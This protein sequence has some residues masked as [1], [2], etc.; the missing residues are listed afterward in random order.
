MLAILTTP[1]H[2]HAVLNHLPLVGLLAAIPVLLV[3]AI[4]GNRATVIAGL[5][6]MILFG[7][8]MGLVMGSGEEAYERFE[9]GEIQ[10]VLDE[11]GNEWMHIHEER[12]HTWSKLVYA[13]TGLAVV[14]LGFVIWKKPWSRYVAIAGIVLS[15]GC[16][17]AMAYVAEAG[18]KIRHPEFRETVEKV[19]TDGADSSTHTQTEH[20]EEE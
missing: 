8:T 1:E 7:S 5:L 6:T 12:A 15:V 9:A 17:A 4:V 18:G 13:T 16:V 19:P 11:A 10:P 20:R 2:I 3:A 14:G